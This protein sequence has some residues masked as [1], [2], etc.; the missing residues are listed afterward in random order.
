M[1]VCITLDYKLSLAI[2]ATS[3]LQSHSHVVGIVALAPVI[4][5]TDAGLAKKP[6]GG[7][8]RPAPLTRAVHNNSP[9]GAPAAAKHA[10]RVTSA[11]RAISVASRN[12]VLDVLPVI[13][14]FT[15]MMPTVFCSFDSWLI[16]AA[17]GTT[18]RGGAA[19]A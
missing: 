12:H 8:H 13:I 10:P 7:L 18:R 19:A 14:R 1:L 9:A 16:H 2:G 11:Q 3:R 5:S 6:P 17:Q 15:A 4:P